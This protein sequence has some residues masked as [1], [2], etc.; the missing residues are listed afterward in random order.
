MSCASQNVQRNEI[1]SF[2]FCHSSQLTTPTTIP[3]DEKHSAHRR[4]VIENPKAAWNYV[5]HS[6]ARQRIKLS[7]NMLFRTEG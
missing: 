5:N 3:L 1:K 7:H 4:K 6:L 2:N